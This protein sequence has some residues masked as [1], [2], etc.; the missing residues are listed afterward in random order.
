M[1][2][3]P[4]LNTI[5]QVQTENEINEY[6]SIF[7]DISQAQ[8]VLWLMRDPEIAN[9]KVDAMLGIDH[10]CLLYTSPSPRDRG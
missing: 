4:Q 10:P 6:L 9:L 5:Q 8:F 1:T 7:K 3:L 2:L